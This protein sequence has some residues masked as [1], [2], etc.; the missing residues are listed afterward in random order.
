MKMK[1]FKTFFRPQ[2]A[3]PLNEIIQP[4]NCIKVS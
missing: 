1:N 2:T 3:S 4:P